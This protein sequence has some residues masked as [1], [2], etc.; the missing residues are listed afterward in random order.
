MPQY[1]PTII[2]NHM[3]EAARELPPMEPEKDDEEIEVTDDMIIEKKN[4]NEKRSVSSGDLSDVGKFHAKTD[5]T[6]K[7]REGVE[8]ARKSRE[9]LPET[10][11]E[12]IEEVMAM[13]E[14]DVI[15]EQEE[16]DIE[17]MKKMED[18]EWQA[19]E[20]EAEELLAKDEEKA[21]RDASREAFKKQMHD[22]AIQASDQADEW[23]MKIKKEGEWQQREREAAQLLG[24]EGLMD[25]AADI[26]QAEAER[27]AGKILERDPE[28]KEK[29]KSAVETRGVTPSKLPEGE[30][31][32]LRAELNVQ[33]E[34]AEIFEKEWKEARDKL[35]KLQFDADKPRGLFGKLG[36]G[37]KKLFNRELRAAH[38]EYSS[39]LKAW[40]K[41]K[42]RIEHLNAV[43]GVDEGPDAKLRHRGKSGGSGK[44]P[45]GKASTRGENL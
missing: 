33:K 11:D 30:N 14:E 28:L 6:R 19:R 26:K 15:K 31:R 13:H 32:E 5:L 35:E 2:D 44:L 20:R 1:E 36:L 27:E 38:N 8:K 21:A 7:L 42:S 23:R 9:E 18:E 22:D 34:D 12:A 4:L 3:A 45:T 37:V 17:E 10:A 40:E 29:L 43:L 24:E 39:K 25:V 41:A 16:K